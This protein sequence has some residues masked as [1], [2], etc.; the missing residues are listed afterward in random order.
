MDKV[1]RKFG[2]NLTNTMEGSIMIRLTRTDVHVD[3]S[4]HFLFIVE[5]VT[6]NSNKKQ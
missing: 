5:I 6:V 4:F 2:W 1:R 3:C